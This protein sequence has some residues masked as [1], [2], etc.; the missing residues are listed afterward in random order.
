MLKRKGASK[1]IAAAALIA[2]ILFVVLGTL[3]IFK[4]FHYLEYKAYE[5]RV[6]FFADSARPSDD[7]IVIL[8]DQDSIDWANRERGWGWPWPRK[9]YA[10][11]V[12]YMNLGGAKSVAF[13]VLFSE[14]SIYRNAE[15]NAII[16]SAAAALEARDYAAAMTALRNLSGRSDDDSFV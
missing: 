8:L 11:I 5:F 1:K 2:V 9:A 10:D 15:Q 4:V 14:P 3:H 13:D 16:D 6:K 12:D 7:I